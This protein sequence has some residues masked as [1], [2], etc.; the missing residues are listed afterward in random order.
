MSTYLFIDGSYF[1]FYRFH[2][3]LTW[4]KNAHRDEP[5][6]D[7]YNNVIFVEKFKKVFNEKIDEIVKKL[8]LKN[9][10][11]IIGKDCHRKQ[12]WRMDTYPQYKENRSTDDVFLGGPFFKLAY[13]ELYPNNKK[14]SSIISHDRLE[15]DDCIAIATKYVLDKEPDS[16]V[17]IITSDMDYLQLVNDHTHIYNLK[18]KQLIESKNAFDTAEKNLFCKIVIGDKSDNIPGIF[19]KCGIKTAEKLFSDQDE[20]IKKMNRESSNEDYQRNKL[21]VDFN[22]IPLEYVTQVK[23]TFKF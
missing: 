13:N 1:C 3:L 16:H 4:W 19:N 2:A 17:Y 20:F 5:L 18:Y 7:P 6:E 10:K 8:K 15:A 11:I 22:L 21:L 9:P 12:I 23:A 14:I